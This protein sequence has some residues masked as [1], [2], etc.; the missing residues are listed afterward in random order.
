MSAVQQ[1]DHATDAFPALVLGMPYVEWPSALYVSDMPTRPGEHSPEQIAAWIVQG[2]E[3]RGGEAEVWWHQ[4]QFGEVLSR[5]KRTAKD[6]AEWDR[7]WPS[8]RR[9]NQAWELTYALDAF[10][11]AA[12]IR[13]P[14]FRDVLVDLGTDE[15]GQHWSVKV[16]ERDLEMQALRTGA[17]VPAPRIDRPG[18]VAVL[19]R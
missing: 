6:D 18:A 10:L 12:D 16:P 17:A 4:H 9:H 2:T 8:A 3:R 13:R 19:V 5:R 11:K 7:L 15:L 1:L 14:I